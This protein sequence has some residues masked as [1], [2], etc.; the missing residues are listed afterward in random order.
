MAGRPRQAALRKGRVS[1]PGAWYVITA[2]T[3]RREPRLV[4]DPWRPEADPGSPGLIINGLRWLHTGGRIRCHAYVVMP[5]HL[6]VVMELVGGETVS[7]VMRD[8]RS[9]TARLLNRLHGRR[10]PVWQVGYYDHQI[11]DTVGYG[12]QMR[13]VAHN[14]VRKGYVERWDAWPWAAIEPVW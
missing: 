6:H 13:Y 14:P 10:G 2:C 11:R 3:H 9:R 4:G 8:Y 12:R 5:D 1:L 7:G